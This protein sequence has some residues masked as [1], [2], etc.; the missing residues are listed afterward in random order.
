[1]SKHVPKVKACKTL[2]SDV[3]L[4]LFIHKKYLFPELIDMY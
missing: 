3:L 4:Y 1:M 2:L